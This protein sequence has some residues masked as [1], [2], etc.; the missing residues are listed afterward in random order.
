M[1]GNKSG[2]K[3]RRNNLVGYLFIAPHLVSVILF[4]FIPL[5]YSLFISFYDFNM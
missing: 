1:K 4:L 5:L 2:I 3:K